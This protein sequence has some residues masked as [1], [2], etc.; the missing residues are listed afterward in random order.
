[1]YYQIIICSG[2]DGEYTV[3]MQCIIYVLYVYYAVLKCYK[4][5]LPIKTFFYLLSTILIY[6][7]QHY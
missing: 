6:F 4:K 1:M 3:F 7:E 2:E 5:L